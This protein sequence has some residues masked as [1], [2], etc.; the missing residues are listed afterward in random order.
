MASDKTRYPKCQA[1]PF[2][3]PGFPREKSY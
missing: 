2:I 1:S 3:N